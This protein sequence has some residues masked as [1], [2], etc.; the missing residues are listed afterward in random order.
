MGWVHPIS[1]C[2]DSDEDAYQTGIYCCVLHRKMPDRLESIETEKLQ[3]V[4]K[5][6]IHLLKV[7]EHECNDCRT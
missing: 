7:K 5:G 6:L 3:S 4:N 2:G 1:V